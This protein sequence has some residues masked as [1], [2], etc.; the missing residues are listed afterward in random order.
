MFPL[1]FGFSHSVIGGGIMVIPDGRILPEDDDD[2]E[3]IPF[4]MMIM[5]GDT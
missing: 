4:I 3:I 2:D 1:L 5:L